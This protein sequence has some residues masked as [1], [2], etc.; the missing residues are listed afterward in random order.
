MERIAWAVRVAAPFAAALVMGGFAFA[1]D[2]RHPLTKWLLVATALVFV[3]WGIV[4]SSEEPAPRNQAATPAE[5]QGMGP[6]EWIALALSGSGWIWIAVLVIA[7]VAI[8]E[9]MLGL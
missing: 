9:R 4:V 5:E 7:G 3:N 1:M 2:H 8:G 6:K